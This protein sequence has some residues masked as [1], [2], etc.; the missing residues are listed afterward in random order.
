MRLQKSHAKS[1]FERHF[2]LLPQKS[3]IW[4]GEFCLTKPDNKKKLEESF[5]QGCENLCAQTC[6]TKADV[7]RIFYI[8]NIHSMQYI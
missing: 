2:D 8:V 6:L 1:M 5:F 4:T 3:E 7:Y